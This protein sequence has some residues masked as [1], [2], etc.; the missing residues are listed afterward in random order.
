MKIK[1][2]NFY[3]IYIVFKAFR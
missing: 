3:I 2:E 1:S